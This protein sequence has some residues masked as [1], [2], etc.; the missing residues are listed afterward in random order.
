MLRLAREIHGGDAVTAAR[1]MCTVEERLTASEMQDGEPRVQHLIV[2]RE[3][4]T[5][6]QS[7]HNRHGFI[8][9]RAASNLLDLALHFT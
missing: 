7:I 8:D 5:R 4:R 3:S 6:I 9:P 2:G 1:F